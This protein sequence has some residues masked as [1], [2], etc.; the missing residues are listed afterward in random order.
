MV[1]REEEESP[2][3]TKLVL[4]GD[5]DEPLSFSWGMAFDLHDRPWGKRLMCSTDGD[6]MAF[7]L[8][9]VA[10]TSGPFDLVYVLEDNTNS[11]QFAKGRYLSNSPLTLDQ[12]KYFADEFH[13]FLCDDGRHHLV[14]RCTATNATV[15]YDQHDYYYV[16]GEAAALAAELESEGF[17]SRTFELG[18][19]GHRIDVDSAELPRLLE[20]RPWIWQELEAPD[21]SADQVGSFAYLKMRIRA[22]WKE[23]KWKPPK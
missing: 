21:T 20:L 9:L 19:H 8:R 13:D 16:Y 3:L 12:V 23:F 4:P 22:K 7:F 6:R 18:I 1:D 5:Q 17:V 15:V 14:T 10:R 2:P 11:P